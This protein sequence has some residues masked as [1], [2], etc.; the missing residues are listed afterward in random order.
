MRWLTNKR[1][2]DIF[3]LAPAYD[4]RRIETLN[5]VIKS[6]ELIHAR[7]D[8]LEQKISSKTDPVP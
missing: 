4:M 8:A 5:A 6:L 1:N 2:K 7:L 3:P